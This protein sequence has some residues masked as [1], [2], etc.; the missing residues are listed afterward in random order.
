M[1]AAA[2]V[3][4]RMQAV[5]G[6]EGI[7]RAIITVS[8]ARKMPAAQEAVIKNWAPLILKGTAEDIDREMT[9]QRILSLINERVQVIRSGEEEADKAKAEKATAKTETKKAARKAAPEKDPYEKEKLEATASLHKA[10]GAIEGGHKKEALAALQSAV[11][12]IKSIKEAGQ[13]PGEARI[14]TY[15]DLLEKFKAMPEQQEL[16][17]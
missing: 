14:R 10:K 5:R 17:L 13:D 9:Y 4:V 3:S 7:F 2:H 1:S 6:E 15:K 16:N 8:P 11:A 12:V